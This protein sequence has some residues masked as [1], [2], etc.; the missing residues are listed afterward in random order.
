MPD[1][2]PTSAV[3]FVQK[4]KGDRELW[5]GVLDH[6]FVMQSSQAMVLA[7]KSG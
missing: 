5:V 2:E 3:S 7:F 6:E 1:P 4:A